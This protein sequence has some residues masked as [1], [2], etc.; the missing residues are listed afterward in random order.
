[1]MPKTYYTPY[2]SPLIRFKDYRF[3]PEFLKTVPGGFKSL[4][5]SNQIDP[6]NA[7]CPS[8]TAGRQCK[9]TTC[10][11]Q[12]FDKMA[13]S[14]QYQ[15]TA[16]PAPPCLFRLPVMIALSESFVIRLWK[17]THQTNL[18]DMRLLQH[19]GTDC[20]PAKDAEEEKQWRDGLTALIKKLRAG[21]SDEAKDANKIAARIAEYRREF[22]GDPTKIL[23]LNKPDS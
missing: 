23:H 5:F 19:L 4:T 7:L 17:L 1:M 20:C 3:H 16:V 9:D 13:L 11:Y 14:G 18:V 6:I 10:P 22:M 21:N 15:P 2:E 8:E 12:H